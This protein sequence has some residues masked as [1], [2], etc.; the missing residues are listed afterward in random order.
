MYFCFKYSILL[1]PPYREKT[2]FLIFL[3]QK[4]TVSFILIPCSSNNPFKFL[5]FT[6]TMDRSLEGI[7]FL[8]NS[9]RTALTFFKD[10]YPREQCCLFWIIL[11]SSYL[12]SLNYA[13]A[14]NSFYKESSG[15]QFENVTFLLPLRTS[16]QYDSNMT[17]CNE[18]NNLLH[19]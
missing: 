10:C 16:L 8:Y 2:V 17:K 19:S 9:L 13:K 3:N 7:F 11:C 4:F 12:L 5:Q 18:S 15:K 6:P 1:L 14:A